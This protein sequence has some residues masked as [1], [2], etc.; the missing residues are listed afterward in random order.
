MIVIVYT[1]TINKTF[2]NTMLCL[3]S[4]IYLSDEDERQSNT[5]ILYGTVL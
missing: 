2:K 4:K 5:F 1:P 3:K